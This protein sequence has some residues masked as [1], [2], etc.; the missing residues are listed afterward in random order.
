MNEVSVLFL[1]QGIFFGLYGALL[2]GP[3]QAFLLSQI[4]RN[5]WKRTLRLALIPLFSDV[6]VIFLFLLILSQVPGWFIN[7]LQISG[8]S[9]LLYLAWDAYQSSKQ[10]TTLSDDK[11]QSDGSLFK[12]AAINLLNPNVYIFWGTVGVPT[13]LKGWAVSPVSGLAFVFGMLGTMIPVT[14]L[15]IVVFSKMGQFKPNLRKNLSR[16]IAF[17]L[18]CVGLYLITNGILTVISA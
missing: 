18:L 13:I 12:G 7:L 4:L 9:F 17:L 2:P 14:M 8:G 5:G 11:K 10:T 6:P 15:L 16:F 3:F 1:S